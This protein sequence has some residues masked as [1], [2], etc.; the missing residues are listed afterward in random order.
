MLIDWFTVGAQALN[1]LILVWLLKHFLYKPILHAIDEREKKIA[2]E[3]A[4]ASSKKIEAKKEQDEFQHKNDEF[5]KKRDELFKKATEDAGVEK[6]KLLDEAKKAADIFSEKR[7]AS[8]VQE[9]EKTQQ[10][11]IHRVQKSVFAISRKVLKDLSGT[12]LDERIVNVFVG[13][14]TGS[15]LK[16]S[17]LK[18][19]MM[20]VTVRTAF[21]IPNALQATVEKQIK[22]KLSSDAQIQFEVNPDLISGIEITSDGQKVAWSISDYLNSLE[23]EIEGIIKQK[24]KKTDSG[25]PNIPEKSVLAKQEPEAEV[26]PETKPEAK[27]ATKPGAAS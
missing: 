3:L 15:S 17:S 19:A 14:L 25:K 2:A 26:K 7:L 9:E 18:D 8:L 6:A 22:D 16:K 1:F 27:P 21:A 4:D 11:I 24:S 12:D 20:Q 5:D 10:S 13:Q 23:K